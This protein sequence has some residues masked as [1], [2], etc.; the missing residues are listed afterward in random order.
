MDDIQNSIVQLGV[1]LTEATAK[2]TASAITDK[3]KSIKN[4][5]DK[6]QQINGYRQIINELQNNKSDLQDISNQY[7][8]I[9]E[10]IK[11]SDDDIEALHNTITKTINALIAITG[12]DEQ[13]EN[14]QQVRALTDML[15]ADTLKTLQLIGFNYKKAIGEP[16]T[17]I[18]SEFINNKFKESQNKQK[19]EGHEND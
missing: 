19:D 15:D 7:R 17:K 14:V 4:N 9:V 1:S 12:Y 3:I 16:L 6:E 8:E 10:S 18:T 2:S 11:I 5:K 13:S